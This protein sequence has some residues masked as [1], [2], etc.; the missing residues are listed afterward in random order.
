MNTEKQYEYFKKGLAKKVKEIRLRQGLTQ[1]ETSK[2]DMNVRNY[3][4]IE[5]GQIGISV[6]AIY[7]ISKNLGVHPAEFFDFPIHKAKFPA[8]KK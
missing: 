5:N 6:R 8:R 1:I 7:L 4:R 2:L 3:Q